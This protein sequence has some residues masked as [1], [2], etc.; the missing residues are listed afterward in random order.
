VTNN[1][2]TN[3]FTAEL[4]VN[5]H[6]N[7]NV[8]FRLPDDHLREL[9]RVAAQRGHSRGRLAKEIV[10]AALMDFSRFDELNHR[11]TVVERALEHLIQLLDRLDPM[12]AGIDQLRASLAM[13]ATRLL[14]ESAHVELEDAVAWTKEAFAVE[15]ES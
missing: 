11:L 8:A 12:Q 1:E 14:V 7:N 10:M 6:A 3:R 4:T 13:V 15:E 2:L 5:S 9:N